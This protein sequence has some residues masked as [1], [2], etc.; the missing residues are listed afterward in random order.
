[1]EAVTLKLPDA[2]EEDALLRL[3]ATWDEYHSLVDTSPYTVQFLND[4]I[5]VGQ[6][7]RQHESLVIVLAVLLSNY[8]TD[9][10]G[11]DVL[12]SNIKIAIP[13]QAG[14]FNA[15]LSVVK[16]PV[17]YGTTPGGRPSTVRIQ[18]PEIIVEVLSK[19]T[20]RFD[21]M[22]KLT[23]YKLIPSLQYML[24]V[25]QD[26]PFASVYSRT[27]VPDEWLNHDYRSLDSVVRLGALELPMQA[28]YRKTDFTTP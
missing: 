19:S 8:F 17:E 12:G 14:D 3:P 11:Y 10:V 24:F 13:N 21:L 22:E 9:R 6:A 23:Y 20:R 25:D 2:L 27:N 26:R 28:I 18:N 1:M 7:T 5:I 15:D 16:E 4:E